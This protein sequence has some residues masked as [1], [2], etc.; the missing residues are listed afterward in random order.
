LKLFFLF[1]LAFFA[2]SVAAQPVRDEKTDWEKEQDQRNWKEVELKL[3][4]Y[5][6]D[7]GLIELQVQ[8]T[9]NFRFYVDPES[10]A[11]GPDGVVRYTFVARSPSGYANVSYEGI[12]CA[13]AEYK[14]FA[15]GNDGRWAAKDS[16]WRPIESKGTNS[17]HFELRRS[18]FCPDRRGIQTAAEGVNALRKGGH[19]AVSINRFK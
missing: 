11:V 17:W 4:A 10:L 13:T 16:E 19:P 1:T 14:T 8:G 3:P 5:P 2:S 6:G 18:Y 12:R 15:F 9:N 7:K